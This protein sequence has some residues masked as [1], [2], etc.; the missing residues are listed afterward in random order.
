[1]CYSIVHSLIDDPQLYDDFSYSM[2]P[3]IRWTQAI[4]WS[5]AI[6]WSSAI[7]WSI[8]SMD[9][10]NRKVYGD[11]SITDGLV[12]LVICDVMDLALFKFINPLQPI[13]SCLSFSPW[14]QRSCIWSWWSHQPLR[15]HPRGTRRLKPRW[16]S[17]AE[18]FRVKIA[19]VHLIAR[20]RYL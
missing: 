15:I 19:E 5:L 12:F 3:S 8:R 20:Q 9:F 11:T 7:Q 18:I 1:M 17:S 2:I 4:R 10:D 13:L 6:R 16:H 14:L